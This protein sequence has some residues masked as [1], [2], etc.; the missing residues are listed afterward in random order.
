MHTRSSWW[1][2]ATAAVALLAGTAGASAQTPAAAGTGAMSGAWKVSL[3]GQHVIPV[4][5]ELAQEGRAV[6][7]TLMLWNGDV[8]LTGSFD[9]GLLKVAGTLTP[10]DGSHGGERVIEATLKDDGT[11][12]G[13]IVA[14]GMGQMKLTAERFKERPART[15]AATAPAALAALAAPAAPATSPSVPAAAFAGP[16]TL[17][18]AMGAERVTFALNLA[19]A[20]D[21]I[22]GTLGSDHAGLLTLRDARLKDGSLVFAVPMTGTTE[23]VEF[24]ATLTD[25]R[26]LSGTMMGPMGP[27]SFTGTRAK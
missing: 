14:G 6:T 26:S 7:G 13:T 27:A 1:R 23:V 24:R 12:A 17:T 20:G 16:W 3:H 2:T 21:A 8:E 4:G 10:N 11:L 15:A 9:G 18:V 19:V 22:T 25:P 5:M